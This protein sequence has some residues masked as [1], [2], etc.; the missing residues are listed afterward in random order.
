MTSRGA[1]HRVRSDVDTVLSNEL[2]LVVSDDTLL[3]T[4]LTAG[5]DGVVLVVPV[6]ASEVRS[7]TC[8]E[9]DVP[10]QP[11]ST[12][13][14]SQLFVIPLDWLEAEPV[15]RVGP[16]ELVDVQLGLAAAL[17]FCSPMALTSML[18]RLRS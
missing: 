3:R 5:S 10:A 9:L 11:G 18:K 2:E 16:T 4:Q 7:I 12:A 8:V 17:G 13:M 1:I 15:A 14:C 6:V